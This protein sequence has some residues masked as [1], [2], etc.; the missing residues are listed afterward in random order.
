VLT[1]LEAV[2]NDGPFFDAV[3]NIIENALGGAKASKIY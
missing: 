1:A 3:N 2:L